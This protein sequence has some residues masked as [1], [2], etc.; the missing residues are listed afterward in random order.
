MLLCLDL[1]T[2]NCHCAVHFTRVM[3]EHSF[4]LLGSDFLDCFDLFSTDF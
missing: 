3:A 2:T 4:D 1:Q